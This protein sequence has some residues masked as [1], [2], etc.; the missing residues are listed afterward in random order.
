MSSQIA[1]NKSVVEEE[2]IERFAHWARDVVNSDLPRFRELRQAIREETRIVSGDRRRASQT[3]LDEMRLE[4]PGQRRK[5]CHTDISCL[6]QLFKAF[7][8]SL[9]MN[10]ERA[11]TGLQAAEQLLPMLLPAA[12]QLECHQCCIHQLRT[13][14][15]TRNR[16]LVVSVACN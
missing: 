4:F 3:F 6:R 5:V 8:D 2:E 15:Q 9:P 14:L 7:V 12:S 13:I 16:R 10:D 11:R 1:C